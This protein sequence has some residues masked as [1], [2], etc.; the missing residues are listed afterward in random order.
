MKNMEVRYHDNYERQLM[1]INQLGLEIKMSKPNKRMNVLVVIN[2]KNFNCNDFH[3][4]WKVCQAYINVVSN[5][6]STILVLCTTR[7]W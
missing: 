1:T 6:I 5:P 7:K 2:D 4:G 3:L